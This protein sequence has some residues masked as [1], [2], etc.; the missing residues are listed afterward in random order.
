MR[1]SPEFLDEI[2][3]RLP[4]SEVVGRRIR[5]KKAGR[6]W[7]GLSPFNSEKTP[8]FYVNDGKMAWFDFSS[9]KNGNI[10]DFVMAT[11]GLTFLE[12]VERLAGEA[13]LA[14][15]Q[16]TPESAEHE[17]KRAGLHEVL[18]RA[19]EFFQARLASRDGSRAR[20]YL[21]ERQMSPASQ[22]AFRIGY[23]PNDRHA[24][25]DHLAGCNASV[26]TMIEAG[27]LVHGEDIVVPYDRFRDRVMF[28]ICDRSGRVIA[29]GGRALDKDVG[30]KY[31]NSPETTLFHKGAVLYN[32]HQARKPASDKGAVIAVEGY[33]DVVAMTAVGFPNVVAPLGTALTP[34]QCELLWRL[35][36]TPIL[37]FDGDAAGRRAA[38]KAV[39]TA[40]PLIAPNR[41]FH[42]AFLP[43]GQDPDDLARA[44]G[45]TAI[46]DVLGKAKPLVDV[47]WLRETEGHAFD[48]PEQRAGL[49]HRLGDLVRGIGDES[50]RRHYGTALRDR[51]SVL[52]GSDARTTRPRPLPWQ[53][54]RQRS[55]RGPFSGSPPVRGYV[56]AA[57]PPASEALTRSQA[58]SRAAVPQRE[59]L[60]LTS[61][62]TH[63][64]LLEQH[65][66]DLAHIEFASPEAR[67]LC[68]AIVRLAGE[69]LHDHATLRRA[70]DARGLSDL[71]QRLERAA[72]KLPHWHLRSDASESDADH[73][74]RQALTLQRRAQALHKALRVA[75]LALAQEPSEANLAL[76][77]D[78]QSQI[79]T[80]NGME[81]TV[82]GFGLSSGRPEADI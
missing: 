44:G 47:L 78:V 18:E 62:L 53:A 11:E 41:S 37:C 64:R 75:E 55:G 31:L 82:D 16:R 59:A 46:A 4:V 5:L 8:S 40:L 32:H 30:A 19:A 28:P 43:D 76:L 13:G 50:L 65:F 39:E 42:F 26:E 57:L 36:E 6:E 14:L 10:F 51:L 70:L 9:G 58:S 66:E 52:L 2:K 3:T 45:A 20:A 33:V 24:L 23:A 54:A 73:V 68:D 15:P 77:C 35:A 60:I 1:L 71:R 67:K 22:A 49:E 29:F 27:L 61:L 34:D 69:D 79:A 74:L 7:R 72:E 48:T 80:L 81:A 56:S 17:K 25:R 12:A 21:A 63:P 38:F